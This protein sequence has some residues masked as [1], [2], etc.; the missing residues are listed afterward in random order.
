MLTKDEILTTFIRNNIIGKKRLHVTLYLWYEVPCF[1]TSAV[2]IV[3]L[4]MSVSATSAS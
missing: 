1:Q 4:V 3:A 2:Q